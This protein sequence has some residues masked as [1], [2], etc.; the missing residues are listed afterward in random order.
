[1]QKRITYVAVTL[2]FLLYIAAVLCLCLINF[3][4]TAQELPSFIL[5]IPTDKLVHFAMFF[6]YPA[7]CWLM[8]TYNKRIKMR[9]G[10]V[11]PVM[12]ITGLMFAA[13]TETAQGILTTCRTPDNMDFVADAIGII[14]CTIAIRIAQ[15]PL[16]ALLDKIQEHCHKM[17]H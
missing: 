6:A 10:S 12:V 13:F 2:L 14:S 9:P 15:K 17:L 5:G 7:V 4:D 16:T 1:M 8:L 3:S 11:F